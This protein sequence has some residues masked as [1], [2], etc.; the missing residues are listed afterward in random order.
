MVQLNDK[1]AI[2][3]RQIELLRKNKI[4]EI[5]VITGYKSELIENHLKKRN[6]KIIHNNKFDKYDTLYSIYCAKK[7]IKDN[8][9]CIYGDLVFNESVLSNLSKNKNN[10]NLVI[11]PLGNEIDSHSVITKNSKILNINLKNNLKK[12]NG[13][14]I[15]MSS[16]NDV[17]VDLVKNFLEILS[18]NDELK[19][20][21]VHLIDL[22][23]KKNFSFHGIPIL[24][25]D[26][27]NVNTRN[28]LELARKFVII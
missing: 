11:G 26:W 10:G 28:H 17:Y 23:L 14:F 4:D 2:I 21:F 15:G 19:G 6:V 25:T 18:R 3:D 7:H 12:I 20:E 16:F 5:I 24:K 22:F 27:V 1:V 9:L 8:F 13:Q